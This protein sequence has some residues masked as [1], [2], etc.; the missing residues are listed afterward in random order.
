MMIRTFFALELPEFVLD[1]I[2]S[3]R[4][5]LIEPSNSFNWENKDKLHITLKFLG[6]TDTEKID[7]I[8]QTIEHS[9]K[10]FNKFSLEL[11]RF[12]FF[13]SNNIPKILWCGLKQNL[14]LEKFV[15]EIDIL[16]SKFGFESEKRKF[17][18]HITMLRIKNSTVLKSLEIFENYKLP[19]IK[20]IGEKVTFFESTLTPKGSFYKPLKSLLI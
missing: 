17:K 16:C 3:I 5:N 10:T 6:D 15:K 2:I 12:G 14:E 8:F 11:D 20:F 4:N 18:P 7:E 13:K 19:E 1:K 9:A